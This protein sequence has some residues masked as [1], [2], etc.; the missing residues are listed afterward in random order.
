[1][2]NSLVNANP[3]S[4]FRSIE[5][6]F[7]DPVTRSKLNN[8]I[9]EAVICKQKIQSHQEAIK[10][11]RDTAREDLCLDPKVFNFYVSMVYNNDYAARKAGVDQLS[12]L[13]ESVMSS[14][15]ASNSNYTGDDD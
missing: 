15:P 11:I 13:I 14:L 10:A 5:D 3:T 7:K 1:L 9:D 2:G 6:I 12:A 4:K 8:C